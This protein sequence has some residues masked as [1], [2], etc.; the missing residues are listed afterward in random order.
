VSWCSDVASLIDGGDTIY[1]IVSD[2]ERKGKL[3]RNEAPLQLK[4]A[5]PD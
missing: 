2:G 4:S 1:V 3:D 5:L